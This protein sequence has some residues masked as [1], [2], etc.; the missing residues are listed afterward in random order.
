MRQ[1]LAIAP[2]DRRRRPI[3]L[4]KFWGGC[5]CN[6]DLP[7]KERLSGC[8]AQSFSA[9]GRTEGAEMTFRRERRNVLAAAAI[10]LGLLLGG[11]HPAAAAGAATTSVGGILPKLPSRPGRTQRDLVVCKDTAFALCAASTCTPTGGYITGNDGKQQPA[12]S[13]LC[14]IVV[15]NNIADLKGG[16]VAGSCVAPEGYVYSTYE[17]SE[18]FPQEIDGT[19]QDA[20][21]DPQVCPASNPYVQCWNWKCVI[22]DVVDGVQLAECTC[23]IQKT[24][25]DFVT[26]AGQGDPA[27]CADYP[28]GG[29][30]FFDPASSQLR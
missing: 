17:I 16:N 13:C 4:Q 10:A 1:P 22:G 25:F 29:P 2:R 9:R 12:A 15:G 24:S 27:F 3:I 23:P 6:G 14:P 19:W 5:S 26:Q 7:P 30:L 8:S 18:S 11:A 28:V 21:A 20:P